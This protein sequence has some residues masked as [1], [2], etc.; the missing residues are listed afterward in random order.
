MAVTATSS[1]RPASDWSRPSKSTPHPRS[2]RFPGKGELSLIADDEVLSVHNLRRT[3]TSFFAGAF[4][5]EPESITLVIDAPFFSHIRS[6]GRMV[7]YT[8]DNS[9]ATGKVFVHDLASREMTEPRWTLATATLKS[10]STSP[11]G[12]WCSRGPRQG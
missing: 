8:Q 6:D 2:G 11:R 7:I 1:I 9:W 12:G 10:T 3:G 4:L 5:K